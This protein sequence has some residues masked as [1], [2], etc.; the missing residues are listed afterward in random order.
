MDSGSA[1]STIFMIAGESNIALRVDADP[2]KGVALVAVDFGLHHKHFLIL[3]DLD[4]LLV[5][6][7]KR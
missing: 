3:G 5:H 4:M 7:D 6:V 2:P 1:A